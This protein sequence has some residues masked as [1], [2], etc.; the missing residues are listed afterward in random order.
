MN[1]FI[2]VLI[3]QL[4]H[5]LVDNF[6][7]FYFRSAIPRL[8]QRNWRSIYSACT[9]QTETVSSTSGS[10]CLSSTSSRQ[11]RQRK[12]SNKFS[13][14]STS[15]MTNLLAGNTC[16]KQTSKR[17]LGASSIFLK[18]FSEFINRGYLLACTGGFIIH[19]YEKRSL[20]SFEKWNSAFWRCLKQQLETKKNKSSM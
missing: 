3:W 17:H 4:W 20:L 15:T 18:D 19:F 13:G 16:M 11:E 14:Y 7:Y 8:T 12:T 10:L 2:T 6:Y 5:T 1:R 9:T